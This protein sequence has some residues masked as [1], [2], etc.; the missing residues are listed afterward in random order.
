MSTPLARIR[1]SS[2]P[3]APAPQVRTPAVEVEYFEP[4]P[5]HAAVRAYLSSLS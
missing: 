1:T 2:R 5:L 3:A 4:S